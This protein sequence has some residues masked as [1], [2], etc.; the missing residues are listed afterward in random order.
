MKK[1][2]TSATFA[3]VVGIALLAFAG[4]VQAQTL[5]PMPSATTATP[6]TGTS[7]VG[8]GV[9]TSTTTTAP[10]TGVFTRDLTIGSI[11]SDVQALQ[12]FLN[13]NGFAIATSGP[14]AP[15]SETNYFGRLTETALAK[16]QQANSISPAVGYFGPVTRTAVNGM[17]GAANN[18][19][20]GVNA[21][22]TG[23]TGTSGTTSGTDATGSAGTY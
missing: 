22:G 8:T 3:G 12:I 7:S 19:S 6:P 18:G 14:G 15:G 23:A 1:R 2:L 5:T 4:G 10:F 13:N 20:S 9:G 21:T 11:G 17:I 16:W